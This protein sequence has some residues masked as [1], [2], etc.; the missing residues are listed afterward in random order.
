MEGLDKENFSDRTVDAMLS[1]L[2]S[3]SNSLYGSESDLIKTDRI[4]EFPITM[5]CV[6]MSLCVSVMMHSLVQTHHIQFPWVGDVCQDGS[7]RTKM[8]VIFREE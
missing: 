2:N 3:K 6:F 4:I 8:C 1:V 7:Y 5:L